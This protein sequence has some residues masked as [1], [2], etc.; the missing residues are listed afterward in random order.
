[1]SQQANLDTISTVGK[2]VYAN[3]M[4]KVHPHLEF[5]GPALAIFRQAGPGEYTL[6]GQKLVF[7]GDVRYSGGA[8]ATSGWLPDHEYVDPVQFE[9]T[10]TRIYVR[11]AVDSF[12]A[13]RATGEGAFEDFVGRVM[14]QLWDAMERTQ[15]R[16]VHGKSSGYTCLTSSRTSATVIVMKDGYG[17]TG[18]D[19]LLFLEPGMTM[20]WLDADNS[21][22]IGGS[23][24]IDSINYSTNTITFAASIENGSGTPTIAAGDPWV[25]ATTTPYTAS[26]FD[27]EYGVAPLGLLDHIDPLNAAS[28]YLGVTE[29]TYPRINPVRAS[30]SVLDEVSFM[31]FINQ[32]EAKGTSPVTPQSHT[33]LLH[34]G[35]YLELAQSLVPYTQIQQKGKELP[36]GWTSV[37]IAGHDFMKD[38]WAPYNVLYALDMR[39]ARVANLDGDART[40]AEDGSEWSRLADYDGK[41]IFARHYV[42]RWFVRRN[43]SG[44]LHSFSVTN[45]SNYTPT[46]NY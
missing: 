28:T 34:P 36:G 8:L 3:Y 15:N 37:N 39:D 32:L 41:E 20:A 11:R 19:P 31:K 10:P 23:G 4:G 17:H 27:T 14:E 33:M 43:R 38:P 24:V 45:H 2:L 42:G 18:M 30:A 1:M 29:A 40:W 5:M 12:I 22:A 21:F 13:A 25:F 9:T 7:A 26:Y 6:T 16:H 35:A 46:P 44:A